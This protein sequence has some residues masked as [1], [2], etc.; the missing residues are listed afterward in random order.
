MS[1][2]DAVGLACS[3]QEKQVEPDQQNR[4]YSSPCQP[5]TLASSCLYFRSVSANILLE[6]TNRLTHCSN[7]LEIL[8]RQR[9]I[10]QHAVRIEAIVD[11]S[12]ACS[13]HFILE[14]L[15]VKVEGYS[16]FVPV[17]LSWVDERTRTQLTLSKH[18]PFGS[19]HR[20]VI[21]AHAI[22]SP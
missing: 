3:K 19:C 5:V 11:L 12:L 16:V 22:S 9:H 18:T 6:V 21:P 1:R 4:A 14:F 8:T 17:H 7:L 2:Q 10:H 15:A 20:A 13:N